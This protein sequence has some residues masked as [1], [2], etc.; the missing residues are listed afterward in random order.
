MAFCLHELCGGPY[1]TVCYILWV[2]SDVC[3]VL[4]LSLLYSF[5]GQSV[6]RNV[7][8]PFFGLAP[9]Y[10]GGLDFGYAS[11]SSVVPSVYLRNV[12]CRFQPSCRAFSAI[13][14]KM[15]LYF[16]T[17]TVCQCYR[18]TKVF[19]NYWNS[20]GQT[21]ASDRREIRGFPYC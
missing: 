8:N 6:R 14:G 15:P 19:A 11:N 21:L 3:E 2:S 20:Y 16:F 13:G 1:Q 17:P 12:E 7:C 5:G 10:V 4:K 18:A 9:V